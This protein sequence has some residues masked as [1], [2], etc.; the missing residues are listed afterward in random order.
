VQHT[1]AL[2]LNRNKEKGTRHT[3]LFG[4]EGHL[5]MEEN[6]FVTLKYLNRTSLPLIA[7]L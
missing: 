5:K 4:G 6:F 3:Y 1:A 7:L 2:L